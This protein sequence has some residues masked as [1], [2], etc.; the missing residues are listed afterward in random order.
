MV[1]LTGAEIN[2]SVS[3]RDKPAVVIS[4]GKGVVGGAVEIKDLQM[5]VTRADDR[6]ELEISGTIASATD[7]GSVSVAEINFIAYSNQNFKTLRKITATTSD[8]IIQYPYQITSSE[9]RIEVDKIDLGAKLLSQ[10][11][12]GR[13]DLNNLTALQQNV[14]ARE[15][16]IGFDVAKGLISLAMGASN[17]LSDASNLAIKGLTGSIVYD[18]AGLWPAGPLDVAF[19]DFVWKEIR[20]PVALATI[21]LGDAEVNVIAKGTSLG[22]EIKLGNRYLGSAPDA[23]FDT[24]IDLSVTGGDLQISGG[25][26]FAAAVDPV[27]LDLRFNGTV[28]NVDRPLVCIITACE[29]SDVAYEYNLHI[30]DEKLNGTSRCQDLFCS[31]G[32]SAHEL[33]TTDTNKF[34]ANLQNLKLISPL[35]L[36]GAYAQM[37]QGIAVGAG[38][39]INF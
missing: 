29:V 27:K 25:A 8:L 19:D 13:V 1:S 35:I 22:T 36:G 39:K 38:H 6:A 30:E 34:F 23:S 17:V 18:V 33:S 16:H 7:R 2:W 11:L 9:A 28:A 24:D 32:G 15:A 20:L 3:L 12:T 21:S 14:Y 10:D 37:L 26:G 31:S 4:V 5:T